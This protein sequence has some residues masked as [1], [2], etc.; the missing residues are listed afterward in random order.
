[1]LLLTAYFVH[2]TGRWCAT[3]WSCQKSMSWNKMNHIS[4]CR[5]AFFLD[6]RNWQLSAILLSVSPRGEPRGSA[7]QRHWEITTVNTLHWHPANTCRQNEFIT[8]CFKENGKTNKKKKKIPEA[9]ILFLEKL[10]T[11]KGLTHLT[12]VKQTERVKQSGTQTFLLSTGRSD[13]W[14]CRQTDSQTREG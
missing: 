11:G 5:N 14:T 2:E 1:M 10:K 12:P 3:L 7:V 8:C 9:N 4:L 6:S 13:R